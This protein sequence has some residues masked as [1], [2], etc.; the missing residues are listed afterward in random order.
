MH[1]YRHSVSFIT[2]KSSPAAP[3]CISESLI[4]PGNSAIAIVLGESH[5]C[6]I[7]TGGT[8]KCWGRNDYGQLGIGSSSTQFIPVDVSL[9]GMRIRTFYY[10]RLRYNS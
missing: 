4:W 5:T 7:V 9:G 2:F 1:T 6:A 3:A 8:L 10:G